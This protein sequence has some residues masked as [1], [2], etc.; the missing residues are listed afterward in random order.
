MHISGKA[1]LREAL[2]AHEEALRVNRMC[3]EMKRKEL[4]QRV[5]NKSHENSLI[6]Y[7]NP[8]FIGR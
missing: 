2:L 8:Q 1:H 6:L 4:L 7:V 5:L 3:Q